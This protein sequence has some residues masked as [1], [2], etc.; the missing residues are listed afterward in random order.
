MSDPAD[1]IRA[2][3]VREVADED[4]NLA[5]DEAIF[6]AGLLDS[7]AVTPLILFLEDRFRIRIPI[8]D[9]ALEDF[10]TIERI[11]AVVTRLGGR[12]DGR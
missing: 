8:G 6:S 9:V 12:L 3:I 1:E 7:F 10:D 4:L 11:L 2:Y 5:G